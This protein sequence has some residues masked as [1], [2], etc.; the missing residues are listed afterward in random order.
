[1]K[2]TIVSCFSILIFV[3]TTLSK[4]NNCLRK[5]HLLGNLNLDISLKNRDEV[6]NFILES[7][8]VVKITNYEVLLRF[9]DDGFSV[10]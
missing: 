8:N 10:T 5:E 4:T 3:F 7:L 9:L 2:S 6:K 1:M